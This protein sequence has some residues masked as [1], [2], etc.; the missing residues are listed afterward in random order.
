MLTT[1]GSHNHLILLT[2]TT[3]LQMVEGADSKQHQ[4]FVRCHI[5][6]MNTLENYQEL[7]MSVSTHHVRSPMQSAFLIESLE[8]MWCYVYYLT[9]I[10]HLLC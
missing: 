1:Y 8:L 10:V 9:T 3:I 5:K 2:Q 4:L 6:R 7:I